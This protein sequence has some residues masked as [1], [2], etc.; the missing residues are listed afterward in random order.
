VQGVMQETL[1][2]PRSRN[3]IARSKH[4]SETTLEFMRNEKTA[5]SHLIKVLSYDY[6]TYTHSVNVFLF[7]TALVLRLEMADHRTMR[8]IANGALLH[9][10]GKSRLAPAIINATGALTDEQWVQMKLHPV[11]GDEIL[12][13]EGGTSGLALSIVRGH[14]EKLDGSGY[15]DGLKGGEISRFVRINTIADVFDALSTKRSYRD[16]MNTFSTLKLMQDE[17]KGQL[18]PKLLAQFIDL[19]G[20]PEG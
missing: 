15:P 10:I 7:T 6:Y 13:A 1:A 9:D 4:L 18:D 11:W 14:H 3:C 16:A 17:F 20:N 19:M 5:F 8:Q 2:D 12:R